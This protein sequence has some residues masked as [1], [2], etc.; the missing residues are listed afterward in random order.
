M[1]TLIL[2]STS[3]QQNLKIIKPLQMKL[4]FL[5]LLFFFSYSITAWSQTQPMMVQIPNSVQTSCS[6]AWQATFDV[7]IEG[8]N[9]PYTIDVDPNAGANIYWMDDSTAFIDIWNPGTFWITVTDASTPTPDVYNDYLDFMLTPLIVESAFAIPDTCSLMDGAIQFGTVSDGFGNINPPYEIHVYN[10]YN[11]NYMGSVPPESTIGSLLGTEYIYAVTDGTGCQSAFNTISIPDYN[12]LSVSNYVTDT[13]CGLCNGSV[14]SYIYGE[15]GNTYLNGNLI[16]TP[17]VFNNLCEGLHTNLGVI[18][19]SRGCQFDI[20][21][22][23]IQNTLGTGVDY[24]LDLGDAN[25]GDGFAI[26][27]VTAGTAPYTV[28]WD[29]GLVDAMNPFLSAGD[30]SAYL[31]DAN[32]CADSIYLTIAQSPFVFNDCG[33]IDGTIFNDENN[34]CIQDGGEQ[35]IPNV[36]VSTDMGYYAVTDANGY[37]SMQVPYGNYNLILPSSATWINSCG[38]NLSFVLENTNPAVTI[39]GPMTLDPDNDLSI[40]ITNTIIRPYNYTHFYLSVCNN[41]SSYQGTSTVSFDLTSDF[42]MTSSSLTPSSTNGNIVEYS[43]PGIPQGGCITIEIV[44]LSGGVT[45]GST[46]TNCAEVVSANAEVD[47]SNNTFCANN[48]VMNSYDPNDKQS[49]YAEEI[50]VNDNDFVYQVRF[51]NTGNSYAENVFILDTIAEEFDLSSFQFIGSSHSCDV[52]ILKDRTIRFNFN[53]IYLPDST[54]NEPDSK[55]YLLYRLRSNTNDIGTEFNNTA[56]IYF[57]YNPAIITNTTSNI[58]VE[59]LAGIVNETVS[60]TKI[61]PN[62]AKDFIT[63]EAEG[64]FSI[65]LMDVN[66]RMINSL[67]ANNKTTLKLLNYP[68]GVYLV[69]VRTA[70]SIERFKVIKH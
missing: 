56:H 14:T 49:N 46:I 37:Y 55:G 48:I 19:D 25:C 42:T 51:Q 4:H 23:T 31:E 47:L 30:Y 44:A 52:E 7:Y 6:M 12:P 11:N 22:V 66:G 18:S 5:A 43:I 1:A 58:I 57:D 2:K 29:N 54:S 35:G 17:P 45:M 38:T 28:T 15:Q 34:N 33:Y 9:A 36:I 59:S 40:S 32:G 13:D 65:A 10:A 8:G 61:Y 62:P 53:G 26:V 70:T 63:V 41:S 39:D 69:E 50:T 67:D 24:T 21:D 20:P 16:N 3:L 64:E 68:T 60:L 27:N